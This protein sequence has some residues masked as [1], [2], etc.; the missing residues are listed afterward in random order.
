MEA[1]RERRREEKWEKRMD[2]KKMEKKVNGRGRCE[3]SKKR[4]RKR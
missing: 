3:E 2:R 1:G 4:R